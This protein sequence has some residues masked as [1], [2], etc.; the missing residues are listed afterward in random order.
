MEAGRA[1]SVTPSSFERRRGVNEVTISLGV[2]GSLNVATISLNVCWVN[3]AAT[4]LGACRVNGA[5]NVY[6][7][8]LSLGD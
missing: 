5:A 4:S 6:R 3:G 7:A 2:W 1:I 8:K